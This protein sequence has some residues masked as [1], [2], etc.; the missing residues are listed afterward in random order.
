MMDDVSMET[1]GC[2]VNKADSEAMAGLLASRDFNTGHGKKILII[3]TCTVK[4]PTERKIIKRLEALKGKGIGIIVT[5]CLP[6]ADPGIAERFPEY[7]FLGTNVSDILDAVEC[8]R[9]GERLVRIGDGG[10]RP[11]C[12]KVRENPLREI[13]PVSSGCLGNC[14]YCIVKKIRGRLE[15]YPAEDII[16]N[17]EKA[18]C[19]GVREIWLT[20]Q[21]TGAYGKDIGES[22][23]HLLKEVSAVKGDYMIR[24]GM[25]NPN[26]VLGFLDELITA[27]QDRRIY[28]FLH[29]PVQSG[30]DSV[31]NDMGRRYTAGDYGRIV[32]GFREQIPDVTISTDVICG[33]PTEDDAAFRNTLK[34]IEDTKPDV[35][36]ISRFWSRPGTEAAEMKQLPGR[37][38]NERSRRV[39]KS[40]REIGLKNNR[41]WL[42]WEGKAL[43]SETG[44]KKSF[45]ARNHAY[46]PIIIKTNADVLGK[47]V[48]VKVTDATFYDLR[49]DIL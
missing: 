25:M 40:F 6:K 47:T 21:D 1:Y 12:L 13:I 33:F 44:H 18:A 15:S 34:L 9:E 11:G 31:L 7:S 28:K 42:G 24:V 16:K 46:K 37:V 10:C 5:G 35:L 23:P 19:E 38:T 3:N 49:G 14:A 27:Y 17:V 29:I 20:S 39:S 41:L 2:A 22:L 48:K 45:C 36:N 26:H 8:A 32:S 43:V 4:G 30:D